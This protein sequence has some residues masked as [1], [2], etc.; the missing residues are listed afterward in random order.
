[1]VEY[2]YAVNMKTKWLVPLQFNNEEEA[3]NF[4]KY[5][6]YDKFLIIKGIGLNIDVGGKGNERNR[7]KNK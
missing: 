1:M 6:K 2:Y 7:I 4:V 5:F 3:K